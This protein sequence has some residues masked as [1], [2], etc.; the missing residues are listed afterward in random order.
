MVLSAPATVNSCQADAPPAGSAEA[1]KPPPVTP[2]QS[3]TLGQLSRWTSGPTLKLV[4]AD[5]PPVGSAEVRTLPLRS[6][7]T[8][9]VVT[10]HEIALGCPWL[11]MLVI[12][13]ADGP[14]VGSVEVSTLP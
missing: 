5:A 8:H 11:S 10:G 4:Q 1:M 3:D 14:P 13:Q 12:C 7:T 9:S 6:P 2:T